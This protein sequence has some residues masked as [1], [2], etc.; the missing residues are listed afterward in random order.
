[1]IARARL[2]PAEEVSPFAAEPARHGRGVAYYVLAVLFV[3]YAASFVDRSILGILLPQIKHDLALADWQLG[4]IGGVAFALF[5]VVFGLPLARWSDRG[6]RVTIIALSLLIWSVMTALCGLATG[7][8]TLM[9][10]RIGVA[11][12]EAGSSPASQSLIGKLFRPADRPAALG[13][14]WAAAPTGS[15]I[16][17]VLG[18]LLAEAFGWRGA[19]IMVGLPGLVL[20]LLVKLTIREPAPSVQNGVVIQAASTFEA[21]KVLAS[22]PTFRHLSVACGLSALVSYGI[23]LWGP[24]FLAR[25]YHLSLAQV[26]FYMAILGAITGTGGMIAGG[27]LARFN[28]KRDQR[29][30]MWAPALGMATGAVLAC[31]SLTTHNLAIYFL[32]SA[33]QGAGASLWPGPSYA[34]VQQLVDERMRAQSIA[35][36]L[37]VVTLIG[38]GIGPLAVGALSDVFHK[39]FGEEALR[40]AM[41]FTSVAFDAW[42]AVHFYLAGRHI[43]ADLARVSPVNE[44]TS[45]L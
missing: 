5:Y 37:L 34:T 23:G 33:L 6:H 35:V 19:F 36:A 14:F 39:L 21:I 9:F 42:A 12:G 2:I 1:M 18:G 15:V 17:L 24:S 27:F 29:F 32:A 8:Y 41:L 11:I 43:I 13:I 25:S 20:S 22:R 16:A 4:F 40:Y 26:G 7:F 45:V 28:A 38:L 30:V 31:I 3:T 10:A 44:V